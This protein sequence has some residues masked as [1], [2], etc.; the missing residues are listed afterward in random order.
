MDQL[1]V[2]K[3]DDVPAPSS[4]SPVRPLSPT[5]RP[6]L[7]AMDWMGWEDDDCEPGRAV[8][9]PEPSTAVE[10][11]DVARRPNADLPQCL[12]NVG[13]VA[14]GQLAQTTTGP[15][16]RVTR[17]GMVSITESAARSTSSLRVGRVVP[18]AALT[19][20]GRASFAD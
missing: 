18:S 17:D 20:A 10:T 19:S 15:S 16:R 12:A 8:H 9:L 2:L 6:G 13:S 5:E 7:V 11:S 14:R 4:R 1:T 3:S